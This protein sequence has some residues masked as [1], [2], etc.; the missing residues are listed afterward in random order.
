MLTCSERHDDLARVGL[1]AAAPDAHKRQ[2]RR[3]FNNYFRRPLRARRGLHLI[4]AKLLADP[5]LR[6]TPG[7]GTTP[8]F[9]PSASP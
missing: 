1:I 8:C 9:A 6:T 4:T 5:R 2:L 3:E 7:F